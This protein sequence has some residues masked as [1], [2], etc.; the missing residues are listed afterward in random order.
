MEKLRLFTPGPVSIEEHILAIGEE[1]PPYNRTEEF[2]KFTHVLLDGLK[3]VFQT[4]GS[5]ALLTGSGTAAMEASVLNF[6]DAKD[7]V[8]V[9][10]G[11]TFGQRWCDLCDV[12]SISYD[13]IEVPLGADIDLTHLSDLLLNN[14]YTALLVNAHETSTGHLFDIRAIGMIARRHRVL[15]IVDAISTICADQ[16]SMDDW[17]VDVAILSSHKALA[18]PPG[19]SF[20]AM[21]ERA[22]ARLVSR[23]PKSLYFNL[24]EY[25]ANQQRG[26]LPY[27]PAIGLMM[28]LHQRLHDIRQETLPAIVLR[29]EQRAESFRHAI[30]DLAF[31]ALPLRPSNAMTALSCNGLDAF[32]VVEELRNRH[33]IFVAPNAGNLKS[34]VFRIAHMGAQDEADITSLIS[35]LRGIASQGAC[36]S[37]ERVEI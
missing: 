22:T 15:F 6:L 23:P 25:L 12:H 7:K 9:I 29:H 17:Q 5:V 35:A 36:T 32:Q 2:S 26:Q 37:V 11:G 1:Q 20:V 10:N 28:Q 33:N 24:N 34:K 14:R 4:E 19:L 13:E 30:K 16:F 8:L 18:L 3:Y 21:N 27:T 31:E